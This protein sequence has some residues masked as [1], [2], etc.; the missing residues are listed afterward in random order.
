[1]IIKEYSLSKKV[2]NKQIFTLLLLIT[3]LEMKLLIAYKDRKIESTTDDNDSV[4]ALK[5]QL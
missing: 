3:I 2:N 5:K 1:M 4:S